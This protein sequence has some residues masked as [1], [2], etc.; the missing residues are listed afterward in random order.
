MKWKAPRVEWVVMKRRNG[1]G[2]DFTGP[3]VSIGLPTY[4]GGRKILKAVTSIFSQDFDNVEIIISDN[5]STDDTEEICSGLAQRHPDIIK[6]YRQPV[7]RGVTANYSFVL[8]KATGDYFCWIADDDTLAQGIL[9]KYVDFL[10]ANPEYALVSGQVKYW[11]GSKLVLVE[12]DLTLENTSPYLRVVNYYF[13][14]MYGAMVYGLMNRRLAQS[15]PLRNRIGDDWHFVAS[16]AFTGKIKHLDVHGYNKKF[17]GVSINMKN[18]AKVIGA[19]WFSANFPHATIAVDALAEIVMLSPQYSRV[20]WLSRVML[21]LCSCTSVL[22]SHYVKV[23]PFIVGGR[24][25]R[26]IRKPYD[27]WVTETLRT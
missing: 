12:K 1:R 6:Y 13:K 26:L 5:C 25:K 24:I 18:Y 16:V 22:L 4:N 8:E 15:I 2:G 14:V 17:G 9:R 20:N 7:N 11:Q 19:S 23:F 10:V 27:Q 21:G 3:K